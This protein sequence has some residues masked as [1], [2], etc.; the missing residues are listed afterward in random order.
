[1]ETVEDVIRFKQKIIREAPYSGAQ[2]KGRDKIF[3]MKPDMPGYDATLTGS[4]TGATVVFR[5]GF[6]ERS[7]PT[8]FS[9]IMAADEKL[10][11]MGYR[12]QNLY[13]SATL[14]QEY[15]AKHE[16]A[17]VLRERKEQSFVSIELPK[18]S[19]SDLANTVSNSPRYTELTERAPQQSFSSVGVYPTRQRVQ[20]PAQ[21][22]VMYS[23]VLNNL[24][25]P[26]KDMYRIEKA[27]NDDIYS[28][29]QF[30]KFVAGNMAATGQLEKALR[31]QPF[32]VRPKTPNKDKNK[33][34]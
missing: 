12:P 15:E 29:A 4:G 2:I 30:N 5:N 10:R 34:K 18:L 33:K 27:Y 9:G 6:G 7:S 20:Q 13:R 22:R 26:S 32:G 11:A 19:K 17:K 23:D 24:D 1:M 28:I 25:G 8:R 14:V 3:Y 16:Q 31:L 21:R